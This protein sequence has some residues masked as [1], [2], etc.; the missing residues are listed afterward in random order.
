MILEGRVLGVLC[1]M[2]CTRRQFGARDRHLLELAADR[3]CPAL[4]RARLLESVRLD[5]DRLAAFS[6][7]LVSSLEEERRRVS[8]ELHDEMGQL[9]TSLRLTLQSGTPGRVSVDE[10]MDEL[11]ERV[12]DISIRLRPP[13][14]EDLGLGPALSWHCQRFA[15]QTGVRVHLMT[16][17]HER[18]YSAKVE[19]AVFRIVQEALTNVARHAKVPEARVAVRGTRNFINAL[20]MDQGVGFEQVAVT[21]SNGLTG[22]RERAVSVGGRILVSSSPGRGTRVSLRIPIPEAETSSSEEVP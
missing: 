3:V 13:M 12:R 15:A 21:Q 17:G 7:T 1:V 9:L 19:L 18:R 2:T 20:V 8:R 14:L 11:F 6:H 5:R 22:M 10:I 16:T 4:D